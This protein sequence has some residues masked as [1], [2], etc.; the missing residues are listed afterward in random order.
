MGSVAIKKWRH[1]HPNEVLDLSGANLSNARLDYANLSDLDL[2]GVDL[3]NASLNFAYLQGSN[4]SEAN[5]NGAYFSRSDLGVTNLSNAELKGA[6]LAEADLL[7]AVL[8]GADMSGTYLYR[9][10]LPRAD[11]SNANLS[12]AIIDET[13]LFEVN[14]NN[15]N[16]KNASMRYAVIGECDLSKC[17]NLETIVHDA[18]SSVDV[19]TLMKS[20]WGAGKSITPNIRT[21]LLNTGVSVALLEALPSIMVEV[22]Y[23]S[24]FISYGLPDLRLAN[25]LFNDLKARAIPCWLYSQNNTPGERTWGEISSKRRNSDKIIVICSSQSLIRDG[26][27]KE[28]EEQIDEDPE[29]IIPISLDNLWKQEGFQVKRSGRDLKPFLL[30]RNYVDFK[31]SYDDSLN[32]LLKGLRRPS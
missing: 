23:Y 17:K 30:S 11:L 10:R 16:F 27:L 13:E 18:P 4:F 24:V 14:L 1:S 9:T 6:Y 2:S 3:R 31:K 7:Q 22:K 28:I 25:R 5:L 8:C 21:F 20:F 29:K 19:K 26:L 15:T 12:N 32:K